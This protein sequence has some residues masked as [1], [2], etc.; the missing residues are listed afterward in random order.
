MYI[1]QMAS[2]TMT[3]SKKE[4]HNVLLLTFTH[5][6][7]ITQN[8]I[9]CIFIVFQ[10]MREKEPQYQEPFRNQSMQLDSC[11]AASVSVK[12]HLSEKSI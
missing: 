11:D 8:T 7:Y 10:H 3:N 6:F 5:N 12:L 1:C 2:P 4:M 9:H